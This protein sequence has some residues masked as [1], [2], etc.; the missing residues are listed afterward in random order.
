MQWI[1]TEN[2]SSYYCDPGKIDPN[3]EDFRDPK[4]P[5]GK[6]KGGGSKNN[7]ESTQ[8]MKRPQMRV[9][10]LSFRPNQKEASLWVLAGVKINDRS[11]F[12]SSGASQYAVELRRYIL[13]SVSSN[14]VSK[15]SQATKVANVANVIKTLPPPCPPVEPYPNALSNAK[16]TSV[17]N[18]S[19]IIDALLSFRNHV[20]ARMDRIEGMLMMQSQRLSRLEGESLK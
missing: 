2:V 7:N 13:T 4:A 20:D 17:G 12:F 15:T 16:N 9:K 11:G 19:S 18:S 14:V 6:D 8:E 3:P 1:I 5:S 10:G